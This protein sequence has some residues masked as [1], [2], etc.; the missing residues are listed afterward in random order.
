MY[1]RSKPTVTPATEVRR[2]MMWP[3]AVVDAGAT[4]AEAAEALAADEIG[5][6]CV[7]EAGRLAGIISERDVVTHVAAG[8]DLT[9]LRAADVMS[10][11]LVT[12]SP[13][14]S[15]LDASRRMEDAQVRHLPVLDDGRIAGIVSIRDLFTVLVAE[16]HDPAVVIVRSG[17]KVM[18]VDE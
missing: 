11:D 14:E 1:A 10:N 5:A 17:T 16:V 18:V 15:V 7:T 12:V 9:H 13:D 6:L 8:A 2:V 4:L 3:V